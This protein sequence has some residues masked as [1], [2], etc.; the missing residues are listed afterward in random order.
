MVVSP[1][2]RVGR[3]VMASLRMILVI[4]VNAAALS[5]A[6]TTACA[7]DR[8]IW[9]K[10]GASADSMEARFADC[11]L[12]A[13]SV[14]AEPRDGSL[15]AVLGPVGGALAESL[16]SE[17]YTPKAQAAARDRC[18]FRDGYRAIALTSAEAADLAAQ[19][20]P[21]NVAAWV[22]AFYGTRDFSARLALASP[23]PL[24]E[25]KAEP[26]AYGAVRFDPDSLRASPSAKVGDDV[27]TGHVA[28]RRT[29]KLTGEVTFELEGAGRIAAGA[30]LH[31]AVFPSEADG[32]GRTYWCGPFRGPVATSGVCARNDPDGYAMFYN[33]GAKWLA[34][35]LDTGHEPSVTT[36]VF[37][38]EPMP[39]ASPAPMDFRLALRKLRP[40]QIILE[41]FVASG[42]D[43]ETLWRRAIPFGA[44][45]RAVVPF[46]S[47]RL[48]L[49]REPGGVSV[50]LA[51]DGDGS[52]LA[53]APPPD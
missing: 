47:H 52:G 32:V 7:A 4:A 50:H 15:R 43:E 40:D 9:A 10:A 26:W 2:E 14:R 53:Y 17:M 24:P 38:L 39:D 8:F 21:G 36:T 18:L 12:Q 49:T 13:K 11:A 19:K 5:P 25:A 51:A 16:E 35:D 20:G 28:Y 45:G 3:G 44:D 30:T 48:I 23:P 27:L 37:R 42:R 31:Q 41:A 1:P 33:K 46:W 34:T 29:V 6:A 22:G